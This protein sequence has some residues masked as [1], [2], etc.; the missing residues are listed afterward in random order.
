MGDLNWSTWPDVFQKDF[1]TFWRRQEILSMCT[2]GTPQD[3][4]EA[5]CSEKRQRR[6]IFWMWNPL[7]GSNVEHPMIL[8]WFITHNGW[9]AR[10]WLEDDMGRY[11]TGKWTGKSTAGKI[12][13]TCRSWSFIK[14]L[15]LVSN[16]LMTNITT[17]WR[18]ACH[19]ALSCCW[20]RTQEGA[21]SSVQH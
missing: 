10:S 18:F 9:H 12:T 6:S 16:Y 5:T 19:Q 17:C 20:Q 21:V 4:I 1:I 3:L 7:Q 2:V 8:C 11:S 14:G 13:P 15:W